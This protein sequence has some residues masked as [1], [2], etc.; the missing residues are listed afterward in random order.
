MMTRSEELAILGLGVDIVELARIEKMHERHGERLVARFCRP[1]E[2]L[3]R[4]GSAL[5]EHLG[6]RADD[7]FL[8]WLP[9]HHDMGLIGFHL[10]PI[11]LGVD[12][13]VMHP[14]HFLKRPVAWLKARVDE[15]LRI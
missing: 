5:I 15:E 6:G 14:R 1:G 7:V 3:P 11:V 13:V 2:C 8:S 4:Q 9:L 10:L 12:Q